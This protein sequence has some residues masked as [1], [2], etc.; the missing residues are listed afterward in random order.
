MIQES[1]PAFEKVTVIDED[2]RGWE[3]HHF[4]NRTETARRYFAHTYIHALYICM[5]IYIL[6]FMIF[7]GLGKWWDFVC[8]YEF[9]CFCTTMRATYRGTERGLDLF[10]LAFKY[11]YACVSV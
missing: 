3:L 7:Y 8:F 11:V 1:D 2:A 9:M 6:V 10:V 4:A 5:Y